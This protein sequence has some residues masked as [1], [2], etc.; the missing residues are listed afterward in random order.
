MPVE[1]VRT[2]SRAF[3]RM[4]EY[5]RAVGEPVQRLVVSIRRLSRLSNWS[6]AAGDLRPEPLSSRRWGR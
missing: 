1:R 6:S 5:A 4:V 3:E 2:A